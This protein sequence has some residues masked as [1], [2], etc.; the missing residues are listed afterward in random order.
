MRWQKVSTV[1]V[2]EFLTT[3]KRPGYLIATFGMPLFMAAYAGIIG[4][5]AYYADREESTSVLFGVVDHAGVLGLSADVAAA[6]LLRVPEEMRRT[7]EATGQGPALDRVLSS[8]RF[9][10]RRFGGETEARAALAARRI[11]GFFVLPADYLQEGGIDAYSP[12]SF[13]FSAPDVRD[14]FTDL[15]RERIVSQRMDPAIAPR[16][17]QPIRKTQQFA[18][19][20]A[21]EVRDGGSAATILR[22]VLPLVF[23]VL[24]LLSVL[25]TSGY[26]MQGTATEKENKVVEVLLASASPDEI[27]GGKLLGLG[28]AGLL[29]MAL[30]LLMALVTGL[31]IVPMLVTAQ[32]DVPW[33]AL[34][35]ALPFFIVAFLF[36]GG[37]I[38][39]TGSLG[40]NMREAQQL[41]MVWS[42]IAALP[43]ML[44]VVL[45]REPHGALSRVLTWVPFTSGPVIVLRASTDAAALASWEIAG[46]LAVLMASTW[47]ALRVGARLFRIGLLSAGSRPSLREV[48]RQARLAK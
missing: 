27:L 29:Q 25:M 48:V 45:V 7:L 13:S 8:S 21:G 24:F 15:V 44:M 11:E 22:L 20:R 38:L 23:M 34:A 41:A 47:I 39:G 17:L 36:F 33:L 4:I 42:L 5:T 40:A 28:G 19:T 12:D 14:A 35:V 16:V 30:W 2:F 37:L 18:V 3:V 1:A 10:F 6:P 26:L 31:G 32:I 43:L 46:A 9:V